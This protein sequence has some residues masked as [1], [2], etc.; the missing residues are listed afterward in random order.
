MRRVQAE[1]SAAGWQEGLRRA[2]RQYQASLGLSS[3]HTVSWERTELRQ[4]CS[5][6]SALLSAGPEVCRAA[7]SWP[8]SPGAY[9]WDVIREQGAAWSDP[10]H[11]GL[12]VHVG[13]GQKRVPVGMDAV[14][15]AFP[16]PI[17][18]KAR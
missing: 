9:G 5:V 4:R 14:C 17:L 11:Q 16:F 13:E 3:L 2:V 12:N 8:A 1:P 18:L 10:A 15:A 6:L 7:V